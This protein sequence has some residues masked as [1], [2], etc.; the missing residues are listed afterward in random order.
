MQ[1]NSSSKRIINT[2]NIFDI[3]RIGSSD[4]FEAGKS[5]TLGID[6]KREGKLNNVVTTK[7]INNFWI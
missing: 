4:T 2:D 5:L 3:N 1:N 6:Y 7:D